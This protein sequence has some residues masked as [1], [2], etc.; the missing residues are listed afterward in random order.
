MATYTPNFNLD[1]YESTDKPNL[2]DQ[3]NGAMNK[4]DGLLVTQQTSINNAVTTANKALELSNGQQET[5]D[6]LNTR[7]EAAETSITDLSGKVGTLETTTADNTSKIES[8][9]STRESEVEALDTRVTALEGKQDEDVTLTDIV[10]IGDSYA[11]GYQPTGGALAN[12]IAKVCADALGLKLHSFSANAAGYIT[13]GDNSKSFGILEN[14]AKADATSKAYADKVKFVV[15]I[16]GR[17]DSSTTSGFKSTAESVLTQAQKDFPNAQV[18]A[19]YLWDAY[20]RPNSNQL[21]NFRDLMSACNTHGVVSDSKSLT[22]GLLEIFM[23]AGDKGTDIHPNG[24]GAEF[25]G[26]CIAQVLC[27]G[28]PQMAHEYAL[29]TQSVRFYKSGSHAIIQANG[30]NVQGNADVVIASKIPAC[31]AFSVLQMGLT[32]AG[33]G[34]CWFR[35]DANADGYSANLK[36]IGGKKLDNTSL[37]ANAGTTFF[38]GVV[39]ML[40]AN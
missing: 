12:N 14:D 13:I 33:D 9:T 7:V 26:G 3:Y 38:S 19:F 32:A 6:E 39:D 30:I 4:I 21:Q 23:Y 1:L 31:L 2:R 10:I 8:E 17:N 16:G 20:R 25:L 35:C 34:I 15:F 24:V 11:T 22:W 18:C 5:V 37:D 36:M 40:T 28:D 29:D 27:G